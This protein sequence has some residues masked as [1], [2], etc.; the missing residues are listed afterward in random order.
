[1]PSTPLYTY[2]MEQYSSKMHFLSSEVTAFTYTAEKGYNVH[3]ADS[4]GPLQEPT[5]PLTC[6]ATCSDTCLNTC[7]DTC[8]TC[9]I[10]CQ[11]TCPDTCESTCTGTCITCYPPFC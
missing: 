8:D 7:P 11:C 3:V 9:S 4:G 1:L 6:P 2:R 10:T 5:V